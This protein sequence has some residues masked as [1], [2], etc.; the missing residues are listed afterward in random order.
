M[1]RNIYSPGTRVFRFPVP[2]LSRKEEFY[3]QTDMQ[4]V[5][6]LPENLRSEDRINHFS[7]NIPVPIRLWKQ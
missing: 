5:R 4:I 7:T 1:Q 2:V 3:M 6:M